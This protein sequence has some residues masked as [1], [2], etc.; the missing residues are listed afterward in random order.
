[1]SAWTAPTLSRQLT[2]LSLKMYGL[3]TT[4]KNSRMTP[5]AHRGLPFDHH[6]LAGMVSPRRLLIIDNLGYKWLSPC[7]SYECLT[8]ARTIYQALGAEQ[9]IGYSQAANHTHC[10]FPVEV[11]GAELNMFV[12]KHLRHDQVDGSAFRTETHFPFDQATWI[13]SQSPGLT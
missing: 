4:L 2:R 6:M 7:S 12:S 13:K 8:A 10:H 3:V 11:Q 1:M 5:M 9:A